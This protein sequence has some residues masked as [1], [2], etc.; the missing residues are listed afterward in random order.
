[1]FYGDAD[2]VG[3]FFSFS[4][5]YHARTGYATCTKI[6]R[7]ARVQSGR[8]PAWVLQSEP[9]LHVLRAYNRLT[10]V[11]NREIAATTKTTKTRRAHATG[12]T[13]RPS[14]IHIFSKEEGSC[15]RHVRS[16]RRR[17]GNPERDH[18]SKSLFGSSFAKSLP[19]VLYRDALTTQSLLFI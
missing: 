2:A 18:R 12:D 7:S 15:I 14:Q 3:T 10:R 17:R 16:R 6:R 9:L 4:T 1:M 11:V 19:C 13:Y 8:D 5:P